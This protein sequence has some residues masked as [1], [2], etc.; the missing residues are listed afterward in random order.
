MQDLQ[1]LSKEK[2][3]MEAL[4]HIPDQLSS[5]AIN[6]E[7][8]LNK[9]LAQEFQK[10][11]DRLKPLTPRSRLKNVQEFL[12]RSHPIKNLIRKATTFFEPIQ[13]EWGPPL[14]E[15]ISEHI[16]SQANPGGNTETLL[17]NL[18]S[19]INTLGEF[20]SNR[21]E[22]ENLLEPNDEPPEIEQQRQAT[23]SPELEPEVPPARPPVRKSQSRFRSSVDNA[24][25]Y[26]KRMKWTDKEMRMLVRGYKQFGPSSWAQ[27]LNTY[28]FHHHRTSVDL[29]DKWRNF[30]NALKKLGMSLDEW[31]KQQ[32]LD[33]SS[34][35]E[36][37]ENLDLPDDDD[38]NNNEKQGDQ[39]DNLDLI[40][41]EQ[42]Q[43]DDFDASLEL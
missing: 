5:D 36:V 2:N 37:L 7:R 17:R 4:H 25:K 32:K 35:E 23:P 40:I 38:N 39:D 24:R 11:F 33:D 15:T 12:E 42:R 26:R 8:N 18:R 41:E 43:P 10:L 20:E 13:Q 34:D 27:I 19:A 29:K 31:C 16:E 21:D 30:T 14:L 6:A 1:T 28:P 22:S 9:I 3:L